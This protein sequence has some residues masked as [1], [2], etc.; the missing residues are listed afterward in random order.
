MYRFLSISSEHFSK[1]T[2]RDG[3]FAASGGQMRTEG[4]ADDVLIG[5]LCG[6]A[7]LIFVL[8]R[9]RTA[10]SD[11]DVRLGPGRGFAPAPH[12]LCKGR[13]NF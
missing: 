13:R 11:L 8:A 3:L 6:A 1:Q 12:G 9:L 2:G 5:R 10:R 4:R 7:F